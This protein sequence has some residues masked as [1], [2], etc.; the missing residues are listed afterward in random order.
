VDLNGVE[1]ARYRYDQNGNRE[2]YAGPL[3][4]FAESETTYD[5]QDRLTAW[6][7]LRAGRS[8]R[9]SSTTSSGT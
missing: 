4:E 1:A 3:G 8:C 7:T 9:G 6:S 2:S 5:A